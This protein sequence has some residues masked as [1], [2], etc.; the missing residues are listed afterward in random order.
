MRAD[1][2]RIYEMGG[3][4]D[5]HMLAVANL[6]HTIG[7]QFVNKLLPNIEEA[8]N[9]HC[10]TQETKIM[11]EGVAMT[12]NPSEPKVKPTQSKAPPGEGVRQSRLTNRVCTAR[13]SR[14]QVLAHTRVGDREMVAPCG[15]CRSW[16][17]CVSVVILLG[18]L[19]RRPLR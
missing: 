14:S 5:A 2:F 19:L 18:K 10:D 8:R 1:R 17:V 7:V 15:T 11:V 13:R 16:C 9:S 4:L 3:C 12:L 6:H